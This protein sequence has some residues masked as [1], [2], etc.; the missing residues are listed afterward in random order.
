MWVSVI[1]IP[2]RIFLVHFSLNCWGE[3]SDVLN[4]GNLINVVPALVAFSISCTVWSVASRWNSSEHLYCLLAWIPLFARKKNSVCRGIWKWVWCAF[5]ANR[6][7]WVYFSMFSFCKN[8][9]ARSFMRAKRLTVGKICCLSHNL[10]SS[11]IVTSLATYVCCI[12]IDEELWIWQYL[13]KMKEMS[14][15]CM[16]VSVQMQFLSLRSQSSEA[17]WS[18]WD[19]KLGICIVD[20]LSGMLSCWDENDWEFA[21]RKTFSTNVCQ[22]RFRSDY[23]ATLSKDLFKQLSFLR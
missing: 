12:K 1:L 5:L 14:Y 21:S 10:F 15:P 4:P 16:R 19:I 18:S 6:F 2:R 23:F 8:G 20:T 13:T 7:L 22:L 11:G 3:V 9:P 17:I